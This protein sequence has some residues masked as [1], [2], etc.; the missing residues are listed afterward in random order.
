MVSYLSGDCCL[1]GVAAEACFAR[2]GF[3]TRGMVKKDQRGSVVS[4]INHKQ[5]PT[6]APHA[7]LILN[8]IDA[9]VDGCRRKFCLLFTSLIGLS[10]SGNTK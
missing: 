5:C 8:Q 1:C 7:H 10:G 3:A 9:V 2:G 4:A 6:C